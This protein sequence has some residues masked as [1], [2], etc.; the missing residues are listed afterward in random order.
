[1]ENKAENK[2]EYQAELFSNRLKKKYKELRKWARKNKISCYRLYDRDIPEIPVS[3]DIYEFLPENIHNAKQC[4][5]FMQKQ[6]ERIAANDPQVEPEAAQRRFAV[7][8]LYERPYQKAEDEEETWLSKMAEAAAVVLGIPVD[9]IVKKERKPQKGTSQYE[10]KHSMNTIKGN[11]QEQNHIFKIDLSTYL[12]TGLFFDHRPLREKVR[13]ISGGK[14]VLNLFCYTGSFSV[15][16]AD[17]GASYVESVDLSNTYLSWA[18]DNM[19]LNNFSSPEKYVFTKADAIAWLEKKSAGIQEDN[20]FD[21][22]VL[23]PP[24]FSNSKSTENILDINRDWPALV[25]HCVKLL[26]SN[27]TLYFSTNST[28]LQFDDSKLPK[29]TECTEETQKS[30]PKD[31]EGTKCHRLWKI[32]LY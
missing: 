29:N 8:Y 18:K 10:K 13:E 6:N 15:Y 21:I 16:A 30:I 20:K 14:R 32:K 4:A 19:K 2:N 27:G 5:E 11:V 7:L 22:I 26:N 3:L 23:D 24:T 25:E 12:D 31:F 1:M 17:G 28:K 9:H